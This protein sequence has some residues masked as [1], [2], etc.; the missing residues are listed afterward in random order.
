VVTVSDA[1]DLLVDLG[2]VMITLLTDASDRVGHSRRMPGT[3]AGDFTKT[4]VRLAR[5]L[6]HV[7]TS[8]NAFNS[9]TLGNADDVHHFILREDV[10]DRNSFLH[11]AAGK[12]DFF[13][14]CTAIQLDLV[15]VGL[16]LTLTKEL[17]LGVSDNADDSAIFLHLGEILFDLLFAILGRPFLGIFG[18]GLLF[19]GIPVLV[20]AASD[21]LGEMLGPDGLEGPHAVGSLDVANHSDDHDGRRLD[22][23]TRL[24]HF[25]LVSLRSGTIDDAADVGH[26]GLVPSKGGKMDRLLGVILRESLDSSL[27]VLAPLLGQETQVAVT[28]RGKFTV[29]HRKVYSTL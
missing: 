20:K 22:D 8:D 25:L 7:P 29:R 24:D 21:L 14:N 27:V 19:G 1:V 13:G 15:D 5:Q 11:Q 17:D 6:L 4:L 28:R 23:R 26:T 2:S 18:E 9:V 3:D 16:L 12:V 10:L